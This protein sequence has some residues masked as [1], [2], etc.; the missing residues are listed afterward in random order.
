M[1]RHKKKHRDNIN[2]ILRDDRLHPNRRVFAEAMLA[3]FD[4]E[5]EEEQAMFGNLLMTQFGTPDRIT[6]KDRDDP[7][8]AI[9]KNTAVEIEAHKDLKS[10]LADLTGGK[11]SESVQSGE[12]GDAEIRTGM[13]S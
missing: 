6:L 12:S 5:T 7:P 3:Y 2:R 8:Q 9:P 1:K 13:A 4:A 10:A 11:R